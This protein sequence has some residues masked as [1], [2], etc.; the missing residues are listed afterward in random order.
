[1]QYVT[2]VFFDAFSTVTTAVARQQIET[3]QLDL[4]MMDLESILHDRIEALES[5][6]NLLESQQLVSAIYLGDVD[7][8]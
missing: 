3:D 8:C 6:V 2:N 7:C 1:M 4:R 5:R